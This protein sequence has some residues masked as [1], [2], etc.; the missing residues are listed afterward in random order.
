MKRAI[1]PIAALALW[2]SFS[3]AGEPDH[4][5]PKESPPLMGL[6]Q[7]ADLVAVT[8]VDIE[9]GVVVYRINEVL[10]GQYRPEN[11]PGMYRGTYTLYQPAK[12]MTET[13]GRALVV[14]KF[15]GKVQTDNDQLIMFV[16]DGMVHYPKIT[17]PRK[18][19]SFESY[20][21]DQI[22]SLIAGSRAK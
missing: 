3:L 11:F 20:R 22:R 15:P 7:S 17:T 12:E 5:A 19:V 10:K 14:V 16:K 13:T 18:V 2:T 1:L 9:H 21:L 6:I 4:F 8:L